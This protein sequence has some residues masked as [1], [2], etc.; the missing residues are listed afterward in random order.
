MKHWSASLFLRPLLPGLVLAVPLAV[1]LPAM[2]QYIWVDA[3]GV[4]QLS[5]HPPPPDTPPNRILKAPG[6]PIFNPNAPAPDSEEAAEPAAE[7]KAKAPP[8]LA[9]RNADYNK[10]QKLA[11]ENAKKAAEE[12]ARKADAAAN[13]TNA[14]N[15]QRAIDEGQR[16]TTY[17]KDGN[18]T[19]MDDAQRAEAARKNQ[20]V[21]ANCK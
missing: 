15:N 2:A 10:R 6:K 7:P 9:D 4:K 13:C 16:M 5:D 19:V 17:D 14:R 8:T 12:S 18:L 21:L 11:V 1:S 20:Q 3:K